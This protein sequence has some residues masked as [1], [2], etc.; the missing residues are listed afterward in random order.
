M[1]FCPKCGTQVDDNANFCPSCSTNLNTGVPAASPYVDPYDHT[2]EFDAKD[3]SDN[4]IYAM[5]MYLTL[6]SIIGIILALLANRDS[7]YLKFH[8]RQAIKFLVVEVLSATV[9][10]VLVITFIVPVVGGIWMLVLVVVQI[11]CFFRVCAGK[12]VEP[13]IIRSIDFLK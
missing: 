10:C 7:E 1:K 8:I 2:A 12:S 13:P 4:K 11:I 5:L 9:I 3:V 6:T